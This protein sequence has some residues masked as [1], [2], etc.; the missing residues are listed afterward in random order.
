MDG[1]KFRRRL[2]GDL[3]ENANANLFQK[4]LWL[5][6]PGHDGNVMSVVISSKKQERIEDKQRRAMISE[7]VR[8]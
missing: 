7:M 4:Q 6:I 2:A 1:V 5:E 3:F 8:G